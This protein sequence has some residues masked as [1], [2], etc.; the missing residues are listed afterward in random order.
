MTQLKLRGVSDLN[1]IDMGVIWTSFSLI[2]RK[3]YGQA[4][5]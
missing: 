5:R 3:S 1:M 2:D 4:L